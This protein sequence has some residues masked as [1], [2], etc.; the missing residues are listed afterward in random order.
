M[1][2]QT[3]MDPKRHR[4]ITI[5]LVMG[6]V[7]IVAVAAA[8]LR[9]VLMPVPVRAAGDILQAYGRSGHPDLDQKN[10][11]PDWARKTPSGY[12][13]VR[14]ARV[15][16]NGPAHKDVIVSEDYVA[17]SRLHVLLGGDAPK[18][19]L[20]NARTAPQ[21]SDKNDAEWGETGR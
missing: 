16:G 12:W 13:Q 8:L 20:R 4:R 6:G 21:E 11:R 3:R 1:E 17:K 15:A 2:D 14:F 9:P 7:A 19:A 18:L 10:Y 5:A